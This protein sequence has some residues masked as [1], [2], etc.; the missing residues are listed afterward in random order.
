MGAFADLAAAIF[1]AIGYQR[2]TEIRAGFEYIDLV[3][4]LRTVL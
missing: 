4:T 1:L 2:P 3:T